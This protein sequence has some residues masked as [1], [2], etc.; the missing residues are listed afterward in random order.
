MKIV[1]AGWAGFVGRNLVR[2]M[3]QNGFND[4]KIVVIDSSQ[5]NLNYFVNYIT[6]TVCADLSQHGG[7]EEDFDDVDCP[8]LRSKPGL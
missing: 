7:L 2:V 5:E 6:K 8:V 1:I 3:L 4:N